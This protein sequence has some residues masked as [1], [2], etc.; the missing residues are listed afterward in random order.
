MVHITAKFEKIHQCV[1][2]LQCKTKRDGQTGGR[3]NISRPRA[4]GAA[5]DK[6]V[7]IAMKLRYDN[8]VFHSS[9][10]IQSTRH[11]PI[12]FVFITLLPGTYA[13]MWNGSA[14]LSASLKI[15]TFCR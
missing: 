7:F 8:T 10:S 14:D 9:T 1:F 5:G 11:S 2:E 12:H 3:C 15:A 6:K 13:A 4:Y